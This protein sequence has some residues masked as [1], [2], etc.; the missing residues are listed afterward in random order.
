MAVRKNSRRGGVRV[1]DVRRGGFGAQVA[2]VAPTIKE[3]DFWLRVN[4]S[5]VANSNSTQALT[6]VDEREVVA[7]TRVMQLQAGD[8]FELMFA[9]ND[10]NVALNS[11]AADAVGPV[12]PSVTINVVQIR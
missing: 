9:V 10:L 5:D 12:T 3:I 11:F 1:L 6:D 4:G 7:F 2:P 8:Y